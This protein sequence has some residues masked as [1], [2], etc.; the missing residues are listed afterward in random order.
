MVAQ[1]IGLIVSIALALLTPAYAGF[2]SSSS[3]QNAVVYN[4]MTMGAGAHCD[5]ATEDGPAFS[6]ASAIMRANSTV[7]AGRGVTLILPSGRTCLWHSCPAAS[8]GRKPFGGIPN[9]TF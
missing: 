7:T 1:L 3:K 4:F 6:A 2:P 8:D 9:L 5:G